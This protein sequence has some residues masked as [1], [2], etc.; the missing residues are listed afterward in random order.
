MFSN[1]ALNKQFYHN[2]TI[3]LSIYFHFSA[4]Q[5]VC[6][7]GSD[8]TAEPT[9]CL[10]EVTKC[11][12]PMFIEY[13]GYSP[14]V[15]Y[16][17]GGCTDGK[18]V[19]CKECHGSGE[20]ACNVMREELAEDFQC[21]SFEFSVDKNKFVEKSEKSTCKRL[22]GNPIRCNKPEAGAKQGSYTN[23]NG[24]GFCAGESNGVGCEECDTD[25]CNKIPIKCIQ[26]TV[27]TA[28]ATDCEDVTAT[29]CSQ[30][31][32]I[33]YTG[34]SDVQYD[35]GACAVGTKD[36][37]CKECDGN[38]DAGCNTPTA[39]I[40][41]DFQCH[42]FEFSDTK[43]K[44]VQKS[45]LTTCKRLSGTPIKCNKP[46][47]S[48]TKTSYT[49]QNSCGKC[50]GE[51]GG[52]SC[53]ECDTDSCNKIP[54]K[55][56]QGTVGTAAATDCEDVTATKCSQPKFIE[57]TGYSDV[58]YA[59]GACAVGTKD[60]TCE[61]CD[62]NPDSGCNTPSALIGEDFQCHSFEFS[63]DKGKFVQKSELTTCKRLSGTLTKCNKPSS[64]ATKTS[65]TNQN[66]CGKCAGETGGT[67]CEECDTDSCNKIPIKCIQGTV[68][69]AAATDCLDVTA[70]K[71]SQ[72]KFIEYTGYS[73]V[74]YD[75]GACAVGTK[76]DT[77]E[78]CD[79]NPDA[80]CNTPTASIGEDFQCHSFEFSEDKGKFVQ[81]S[82]MTTC[83][84]LSGTL[85]K[86]NKP[87]PSATKTS[88]TNQNSCGKCAGE[89]GGTSCEEC[90]TDSCNKIPIK[91][92]QGTLGTA[93]ATDC[94]DVTATKCSQPKFIEYTGFS[95]TKYGC[96]PCVDDSKDKT[97][98]E[99]DGNTEDGCNKPIK[100]GEAFKCYTYEMN[101]TSKE[102]SQKG[103]TCHRLPDTDIICNM[104]KSK[105]TS[106]ANYTNT[107]GCGPCA[108]DTKT[109][110]TC[111]ECESDLCNKL[112]MS[113]DGNVRMSYLFIPIQALVYLLL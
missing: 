86:C 25:S 70:T 26:G 107:D 36:S 38:Q 93:T 50:A 13:Q 69:T 3:R 53:E 84:R 11:S 8:P 30:P 18:D 72:P 5:I 19:T 51:T 77:C 101:T 9:A 75:C 88:Y 104:P 6:I 80:G 61:E 105:D 37:T 24:C 48:A 90:D 103:T 82:E 79:G 102:Y 60:D 29:K 14:D 67:T 46:S 99:C 92:I 34:Y 12:Q 62:G 23:Q 89:T 31:K 44:F 58:Q 49:N 64:S 1:N 91:C 97:C 73:D 35:C 110:K 47:P 100:T 10:R 22:T 87:S 66:S 7:V 109:K 71:C 76:D 17:C 98:Q 41:D 56:I 54:I 27:G 42:S 28:I 95:D 15:K 39:S 68:G 32:F 106:A 85:T 33:E 74:Q 43:K 96:G 111:S 113:A 2:V 20:G 81:K 112:D 63:E 83:K 94:E 21:Y 45:E 108:G 78:E 65:Y 4:G 57:Y 52:T 55:C 16:A 59:C 40:G